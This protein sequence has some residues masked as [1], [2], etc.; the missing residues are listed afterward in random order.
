MTPHNYRNMQC[1]IVASQ[2][3]MFIHLF[4]NFIN[5]IVVLLPLPTNIINTI[6]LC[7]VILHHYD[8]LIYPAIHIILIVEPVWTYI[9][10]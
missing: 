1:T 2:M 10:H 4:I 3:I 5:T 6:L 7:S 8:Y 9:K